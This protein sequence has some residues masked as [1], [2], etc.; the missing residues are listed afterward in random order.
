MATSQEAVGK[1]AVVFAALEKE[2]RKAIKAVRS[3]KDEYQDIINNGEAGTLVPMAAF[4]ALDALVTGQYAD[5]LALHLQQ[6]RD[7][8]AAGIDAGPMGAADPEPGMI[9]P[10]SGGGR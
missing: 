1:I 7:A 9:T 4:A 5:T 3:L 6:F 2:Q 10:F 8:D